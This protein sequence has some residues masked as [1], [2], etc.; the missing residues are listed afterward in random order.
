MK[1]LRKFVYTSDYLVGEV[2]LGYDDETE[3]LCMFDVSR[4]TMNTDQHISFLRNC[5]FTLQDL[6]SLISADKA[7]R[8]ITEIKET[9][10]FDVFWKKYDHKLLSNKKK[11]VQKWEKMSEAEQE[12][13]Y[14][15]LPKY[16]YNIMQSG[17]AKKHVETYLNSELWN[18]GD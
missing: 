2:T 3:F 12:K 10:T 11:S 1:K 15:F 16:F 18:N 6:K 5:P 14:R 17:I 4:C 13:A 7:H 8:S 9:I